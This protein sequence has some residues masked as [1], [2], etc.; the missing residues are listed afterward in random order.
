MV[1][2]YETKTV[3]HLGLV[4][5]MFDELGIGELIDQFIPQD[6]DQ[7]FVTIGQAVK[8]MVINGLGFTNRRLYLTPRFFKNK[9]TD[10]LIGPGIKAEHLNDDALGKALDRLHQF[11]V[12][13]LFTIIAQQAAA[14]LELNPKIA[15]L[16]SSSFHLDGS[17]NSG[18]AEPVDGVIQI[19]RG[20]SRD[21]RPD[22]NQ[23]VLELIAEN[24]AGLPLLMRPLSGNAS[25]KT[26]FRE[27]VLR[28]AG[29]LQNAGVEVLVTDSAGYNQD[30]LQTLNQTDV[31]WVMGVPA[32]LTQA[33]RLLD[34]SVVSD[35]SS[36]A[37]GMECS[38]VDTVYAGI[39]Q[40]WLVIRSEAA[41]ERARGSVERQLL[42]GS[43]EERKRFDRLRTQEFSCEADARAALLAYQASCQVLDLIDPKLRARKHY[44]KAGRPAREAIPE[45]VSYQIEGSVAASTKSFEE[46]LERASRFI[47]ATNDTTGERLSDVG[48]LQAYKG[49]S[50]VE[51]G[52]RFLKDPMF[53]AST[54]FLK[55]ARRMM[56]VLVVMTLCVL[57]D[58]A[59]EYRVR[60]V[61]DEKGEVVP[62]QQGKPT[63]RPT[64]K[65]VFELFLDV[66]LLLIVT[67]TIQVMAMNLVDELQVLLELLGAAYSEVDS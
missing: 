49:Q 57:V 44:P 8:A 67:D 31:T 17:Y 56:A 18:D 61:L 14:R 10:Q 54:L 64:A 16:D 59:V 12:T 38:R 63:E 58:A 5:G 3:E 29:Q 22:L 33:K 7:R 65:W 21:N 32:T 34:G 30:T 51:R 42:K 55:K 28:H 43:E 36:L 46:Q 66:H 50:R 41:R 25:D 9:P 11:G 20:Y 13:E 19:K 39:K 62:D 35:F 1:A 23:V 48:V 24:T 4:A 27:A 53:L 2:R 15:H 47:V 40:R 26:S 45:R 37:E 60:K 52:F 6:K